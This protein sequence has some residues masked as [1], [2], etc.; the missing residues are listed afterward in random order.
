VYEAVGDMMQTDIHALSISAL[1]PGEAP[2]A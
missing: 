1:A 2:P